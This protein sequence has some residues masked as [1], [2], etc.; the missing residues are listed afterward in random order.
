M[1][2]TRQHVGDV[3]VLASVIE[4]ANDFEIIHLGPP[5]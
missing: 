2:L 3:V 5:E 4:N 1:R